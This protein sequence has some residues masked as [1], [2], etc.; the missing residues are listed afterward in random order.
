M[1]PEGRQWPW[2]FFYFV[3]GVVLTS[4][5]VLV[6]LGMVRERDAIQVAPAA[7]FNFLQLEYGDP[8]PSLESCETA[9]TLGLL[10]PTGETLPLGTV[11]VVD[12]SIIVCRAMS[13]WLDTYAGWNQGVVTTIPLKSGQLYELG[14]GC[15]MFTSSG[16]VYDRYIKPVE[17]GDYELMCPARLIS[18][19]QSL[20]LLREVDFLLN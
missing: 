19:N 5:I 1:R 2:G 17:A 11:G 13:D 20:V 10:Y 12:G 4:A 7:V 9:E 18:S 14:Q 8:D 3:L 15:S 6:T 16:R